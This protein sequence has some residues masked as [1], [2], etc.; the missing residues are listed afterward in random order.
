MHA[1]IHTCL[2]IPCVVDSVCI[3]SVPLVSLSISVPAVHCLNC[4][5]FYSI[6]KSDKASLVFI[7]IVFNVF[8]AVLRNLVFFLNVN[9]TNLNFNLFLK[10]DFFKYIYV[11]FCV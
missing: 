8:L 11:C 3:H 6:F 1:Y 2:K 10:K 7:V 4:R 5:G 9:F